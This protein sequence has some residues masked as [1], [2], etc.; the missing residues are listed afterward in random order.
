MKKLA[1]ALGASVGLLLSN[2]NA[3]P[4]DVL[5]SGWTQ[6]ALTYDIHHPYDL[7]ESARF[8]KVSVSAGTEYRFE[9]RKTDNP[10]KEGSK[11]QP[12]TELRVQ[13]LDYQG[14]GKHQFEADIKVPDSTTTSVIIFQIKQTEDAPVNVYTTLRIIGNNLCVVEEPIL[15]ISRNTWYHINVI[16]DSP[17]GSIKIY[18]DGKLEKTV[19]IASA[20]RGY[21]KYFKCGT[22]NMSKGVV[23]TNKIVY[24]NIKLWRR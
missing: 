22:Y 14:S 8:Q 19:T 21:S 17:A 12:R 4:W 23:G 16:H 5:T 20:N 1:L 13:G 18:V 7:A 2:L 10:F 15:A 24:R 6:Q 3:A 11:T 9:I